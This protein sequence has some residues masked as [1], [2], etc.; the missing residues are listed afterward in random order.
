LRTS[1]DFTVRLRMS[2]CISRNEAR[3]AAAPIL[4]YLPYIFQDNLTQRRKGAKKTAGVLSSKSFKFMELYAHTGATHDAVAL[5]PQG[6]GKR[7]KEKLI[8][9]MILKLQKNSRV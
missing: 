6:I 1:S 3:D 8:F 7:K 4:F 9:Y 2:F 5:Q